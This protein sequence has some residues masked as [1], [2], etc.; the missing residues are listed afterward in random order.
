MRVRSELI[1]KAVLPSGEQLTLTKEA[2]YFMVRADG[3]PLMS[4]RAHHSEEHMAV[5]GCAGL[6]EKSN[7]RVLVGGLGMG[8]TVH[9]ALDQLPP[10]GQVVVSE[11]SP[12]L[13]EWNRGPLAELANH[14]LEDER[15]VLEVGD[16]VAY[17]ASSPKPFDAILLTAAPPQHAIEL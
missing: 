10:S 9:A 2:G 13:I 6:A 12:Q 5:V 16:L 1:D 11:I 3:V 4:N 14:P 8:Y 7:A 17:L 15:V